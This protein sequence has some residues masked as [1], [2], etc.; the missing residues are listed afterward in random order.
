MKLTE[1]ISKLEA[2]Y[3]CEGIPPEKE[4]NGAYSSDLLSDVMANTGKGIIWITLQTH[5]NIIAV[6]SLKELAGIII[7]L[8]KELDD[9]T[10]RKAK[11]ENIPLLR[12]GKNSFT[13][14]GI[15]Y[16]SGLR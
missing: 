14:S 8:N 4:V 3:L 6:A 13:V 1:I 9:E 16:E 15:L 2:E 5:L 12:T 11:E 7:V 10:I